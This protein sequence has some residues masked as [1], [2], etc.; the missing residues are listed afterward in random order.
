MV[1][2]V[3]EMS[4]S[5]G[6]SGPPGADRAKAGSGPSLSGVRVAMIYDCLFPFTVGGGERWYRFVAEH[7]VEAGAEVTYLTRRQWDDCPPDI[8]GIRIV[9][10][11]RAED[12]YDERG[13]RRLGP[14]L[15]FGLGVGRYLATHRRKFDVVEVANF[16]FWSL[17]AARAALTGARVPAV[18]DWHEIWSLR[19]WRSYAG[20]LTGSIGFVVQLLCAA[21]SAHPIV[22]SPRN[23]DRLAAAGCPN[24][25]V[26][27]AGYLPAPAPP[28]DAAPSPVTPIRP[29]VA[30]AGRHIHDKGV[31]LL[32]D[33][34]AELADRGRRVEL[35]VAGDG[36][37]RDALEADIAAR[38]LPVR[39]IGF[40]GD[41]EL[42]TLLRS[43]A[44][45]VVPSRREG[46][47]LLA[48]EAT[49]YG[50]PLV[51]AGFEENLAIDHVEEGRNGYVADPPVASTIAGC[52]AEVI[53]AGAPLRR[54]TLAWY[55]DA[56]GARTVD[57]SMRQ[58]L[59]LYA[60]LTKAS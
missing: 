52:I 3:S 42:R 10:V 55:R 32:A 14:T 43:A 13:S 7:L 49:S 6:L 39:C 9:A 33:I 17:L 38:G 25:P 24:V 26:V 37:G 41:D 35:V 57:H 11:S 60:Y 2:N 23:R 1:D 30:F 53:D 22:S 19:Y 36:P 8:P 46:Y 16:P 29:I 20:W 12:L 54:S 40:V 4:A 51:V 44:C 28:P 27:L 18:V 59:D 48:V 31:D 56:A 15:R 50:T 45:V 5:P 47:G 58:V 21:A 34:A